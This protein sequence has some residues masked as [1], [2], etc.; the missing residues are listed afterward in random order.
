MFDQ[1]TID[2]L[3]K[4]LIKIQLTNHICFDFRLTYLHRDV[5]G[6]V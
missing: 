1:N 4:N 5:H 3:F 2:K 6:E